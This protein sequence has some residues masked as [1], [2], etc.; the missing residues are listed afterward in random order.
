MNGASI[1][2][3]HRANRCRWLRLPACLLPFA[4]T[5]GFLLCAR[6]FCDCGHLVH[7]PY[8]AW[9]ILSDYFWLGSFAGAAILAVCLGLPLRFYL[10]FA[11]GA[12]AVHRL[13]LNSAVGVAFDVLWLAVVYVM[14]IREL[15]RRR[16]PESLNSSA[17]KSFDASRFRV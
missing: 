9:Y 13:L 8:P 4:G 12:L 15:T 6:H 14:C 16:P 3:I 2:R 11:L 7:P 10:A 5:P 17:D 1:E